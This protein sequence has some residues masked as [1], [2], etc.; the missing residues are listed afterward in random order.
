LKILLVTNIFPPEIGGPASYIDRLGHALSSDGTDVTVVCVSRTPADPSDAG[1]PF[2]VRRVCNRNRIKF[3]INLRRTL[4]IELARH[5]N[6]LVNGLYDRVYSIAGP[7]RRSYITKIVGDDAWQTGRNSGT[8]SVSID[9]FQQTEP[10]NAAL[11]SLVQRRNAHVRHASAVIV[12]SEYLKN[13]VAG[14]GVPRER[15]RVIHNGTR[16][17][18]YSKY[19]PRQREGEKMKVAFVGRLTN[20]KGVETILLAARD[21]DGIDYTIIGDGPSEPMLRTLAAQLGLEESVRFTGRL[22]AA[23]VREELSRCHAL[24]L[25]SQYEGLSHTLL[26]ACAMGLPCIASDCGGNP[27]TIRE[28]HS[29]FLIPYGDPDAL[30]DRLVTLRDDEKLRFKLAT[31]AKDSSNDFSFDK[32]MEETIKLISEVSGECR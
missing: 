29:G 30:R 23:R 8:C 21:T 32:T 6:V 20:W 25:T 16:L 9:E 15:I 5:R 12:P 27:E 18:E 1:R 17:Q 13:M 3:E 24:V 4:G 26:E 11:R 10:E 22:D 28:G 2:R 19:E 14:W 7:M 31:G